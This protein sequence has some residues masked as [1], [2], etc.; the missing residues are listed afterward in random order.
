MGHVD[1]WCA[2]TRRRLHSASLGEPG[3]QISCMAAAQTDHLLW[4]GTTN[5]E[6]RAMHVRDAATKP[7]Q[8]CCLPAV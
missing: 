2:R 5:G 4:C 7:C 8:L 1:V 3:V 6:V